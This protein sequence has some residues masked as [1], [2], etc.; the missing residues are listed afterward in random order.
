MS[1]QLRVEPYDG[2]SARALV[3]AVQQE[4]VARYGGQDETPV[5]P[6]EFAAPRGV[7][8]VGYDAGEPVACGGWR[9]RDGSVVDG[10]DADGS[11]AQG[12][13]AE[14]KRMFVV[15]GHR[16]RGHARAVLAELESLARAAGVR[17]MVLETGERQPEAVALYASAGYEPVAPF[18]HYA[19]TPGS[20]HLGKAL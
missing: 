1:I 7:F 10:L 11:V 14:V 17:R 18:G 16:G 13:D 12:L 4:Y 2:P 6:A 9:R 20:V 15:A 19:C 5:H 8:L 3:A